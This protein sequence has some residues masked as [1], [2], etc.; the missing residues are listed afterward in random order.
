MI[1]LNRDQV[2]DF[3]LKA[4]PNDLLHIIDALIDPVASYIGCATGIE[5]DR[6][7]VLMQI[8]ESEK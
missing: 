5:D 8:L 3:I 2:I 4:K 1:D 6:H 7:A